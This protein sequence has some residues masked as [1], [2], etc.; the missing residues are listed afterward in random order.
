MAT[1][2]WSLEELEIII[3]NFNK[4][5]VGIQNAL[6]EAGFVRTIEAVK[7][8]KRSLRS[9]GEMPA[10]SRDTVEEESEREE[11]LDRGGLEE[12]E[13][14]FPDAK[15]RDIYGSYKDMMI[16]IVKEAKEDLKARG[17][18]EADASPVSS[19]KES[20]VV[21]LS[22]LHIGKVV[23][24]E[25]V[26]VYNTEIALKRIEELTHGIQRVINH[27]RM[28]TQIDEIVIL[29]L[30]D[31]VDNE[32]IYHS[33][34]HHI[35]SHVALQVKNTIRALWK[36]I[37]TLTE[38]EGV[39]KVRVLCVR[40]NHG[41]S[42]AIGG[43]EDSNFDT[44]VHDGLEWSSILHNDSR[45]TVSSKYSQFNIAEVKGHRILMRHEAPAHADTSAA[46]SRISGWLDL[47]GPIAAITYGH[48]HHPSIST[49]NDRYLFMNGSL[50]GG[51]DLSE[52]MAVGNAPTQLLFGVT[53][54]RL[55][56]FIY[57][58]IL[59]K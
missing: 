22:D 39:E 2:R 51:D 34:A 40:G 12:S 17:G 29:C 50:V 59:G 35:D 48:L 56:S 9:S 5:R 31:L 4:S 42:G 18:L 57:P 46:K 45:I 30:G 21:M 25:G 54:K 44:I 24:N 32:A 11:D 8:K 37:I 23:E 3:D 52:R 41:R 49:Y 26:D 55:P 1:D 15:K 58:I 53:R 33:H 28:G 13:G 43:H 6:S 36:M 20:I 19:D 38:I 47:H 27:A 7:A 10:Y 16:D 14:L